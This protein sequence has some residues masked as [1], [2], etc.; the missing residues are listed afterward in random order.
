MNYDCS[1]ITVKTKNSH[2]RSS[3][4][5]HYTVKNGTFSYS[6][7]DEPEITSAK[8]NHPAWKETSIYI[9]INHENE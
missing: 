6:Y 9:K 3:E 8:I 7:D 2:D 5:Q 4:K 1:E